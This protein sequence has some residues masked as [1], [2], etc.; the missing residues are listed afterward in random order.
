MIFLFL[1]LSEPSFD[2]FFLLFLFLFLEPMVN[3]GVCVA[4][5]RVLGV[6]DNRCL[7]AGINATNTG[8]VET[9][10]AKI[11]LGVDLVNF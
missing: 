7:D 1:L 2:L 8:F 11:I 3:S 4:E 10:K 5:N 9:A 6:D